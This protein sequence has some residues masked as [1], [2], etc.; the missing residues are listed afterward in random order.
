LADAV[1]PKKKKTKVAIGERIRYEVTHKGRYATLRSG[2]GKKRKT[3]GNI[4]F[5]Q[6]P[7]WRKRQYATR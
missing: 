1:K 3:H 7:E 6:L 5:D 2:S 4:K